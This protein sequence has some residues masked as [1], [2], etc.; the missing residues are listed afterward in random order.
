MKGD[1]WPRLNVL[2][3]VCFRLAVSEEAGCDGLRPNHGSRLR[4]Y[5]DAQAAALRFRSSYGGGGYA[6]SRAKITSTLRPS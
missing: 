1:K 5:T 4:V 6:D 3:K 2:L